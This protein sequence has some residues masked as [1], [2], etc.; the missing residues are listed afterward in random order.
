[1]V[2]IELKD[3]LQQGV[4]YYVVNFNPISGA[5][6]S[7][8]IEK[9]SGEMVNRFSP[10]NQSLVYETSITGNTFPEIIIGENV[11]E[12]Y[13]KKYYNYLERFYMP[14]GDYT[15]VD[16]GFVNYFTGDPTV[17]KIEMAT[18]LIIKSSTSMSYVLKEEQDGKFPTPRNRC[19]DLS[20]NRSSD[21]TYECGTVIDFA[22]A[23]G[24][25]VSAYNFSMGKNITAI[26]HAVGTDL[27][28]NSVFLGN[29]LTNNTSTVSYL[30]GNNLTDNRTSTLG[31]SSFVIGVNKLIDDST[32]LILNDNIYFYNDYVN[33]I[34]RR[35]K[36]FTVLDYTVDES[37]AKSV[38]NKE[39]I[40]SFS[41][42]NGYYSVS[43]ST[44]TG[45]RKIDEADDQKAPTGMG[46]IDYSTQGLFTNVSRPYGDYSWIFGEN[47]YT[48]TTYSFISGKD[49]RLYNI[50][51]S[52]IYSH[53]TL[54]GTSIDITSGMSWPN[55]VIGS[56]V[57]TST[58]DTIG[59]NITSDG[60]FGGVTRIGNNISALSGNTI[61]YPQAVIIGNDITLGNNTFVGDSHV[62]GTYTIIGNYINIQNA[63]LYYGYRGGI[64]G[65]NPEN[66]YLQYA[67]FTFA[68]GTQI[69]SKTGLYIQQENTPIAPNHVDNGNLPAK[70]LTTREMV[71]D[72]LSTITFTLFPGISGVYYSNAVVLDGIDMSNKPNYSNLTPTYK[73]YILDFTV[74]TGLN[75]GEI[76]FFKDQDR[77][78]SIIGIGRD[79]KVNTVMS[80]M[81]SFL[82]YVHFGEGLIQAGA[83]SYSG[84]YIG[85]IYGV[86]VF[87]EWNDIVRNDHYNYIKRATL[88][89]GN[90]D[91]D[92][93]RNNAL[94]IKGDNR[95][96]YSGSYFHQLAYVKYSNSEIIN[97]VSQKIAATL[98]YFTYIKYQTFDPVL[99]SNGLV[100]TTESGKTGLRLKNEQDPNRLDIG[101]EAV[102]IAIGNTRP[103][104]G[105]SGDYAFAIGYTSS[106]E[107]LHSISIGD[108]S[109]S[110]QQ[111]GISLGKDTESYDTAVA[112]GPKA[113]AL[114]QNTVAISGDYASPAIANGEES[115]VIGKGS[116]AGLLGGIILGSDIH[117][118]IDNQIII[119]T[120]PDYAN[121]QPKDLKILF[122]ASG[123]NLIEIYDADNLVYLPNNNTHDIIG[124]AKQKAIATKDLIDT[125]A[126]TN[127]QID[128]DIDATVDGQTNITVPGGYVIG[129][130][131]VY[132]NGWLQPTS[133][134]S[135]V[136]RHDIVFNDPLSKDEWINIETW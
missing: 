18:G 86:A 125:I 102:D 80:R 81:H 71:E 5:S 132:R 61:P 74:D 68:V 31:A 28:G 67:S 49:I 19:L 48:D 22:V 124:Y 76:G 127:P 136:D 130:V 97:S 83:E 1:M 38:I 95:Y 99:L 37:E 121:L 11:A 12:Y 123:V 26:N 3:A 79:F 94:E 70:A 104:I 57:S 129:R 90:G 46:T 8:H 50:G 56:N 33:I 41:E 119:G 32:P 42:G 134:Y 23:I 112:V 98:G 109:I 55:V 29:S 36:D 10:N 106:A 34:V 51:N 65:N 16:T 131:K 87:G 115:I 45:L 40:D 27:K 126:A 47:V 103:E 113:Q 69:N 91:D 43:T 128:Y 88:F 2:T 66:Q 4:P 6:S 64:L 77:G 93:N 84:A 17:S 89:I 62:F 85:D 35:N 101:S 116:T 53:F 117:T 44:E 60:S 63:Q 120:A 13:A 73:D 133:A 122:A 54:I 39:W 118:T 105:A 52:S 82:S 92:A 108:N 58:A 21:P 20:F 110:Y 30:I 78:Y 111:Y 15:G 96:Y 114:K 75:I 25:N 135:A 72:A 14:F 100:P 9:P 24:E 107:G 7:I 59:N